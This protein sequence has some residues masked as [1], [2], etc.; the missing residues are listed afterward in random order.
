MSPIRD[1]DVMSSSF[2]NED[3][4][5]MNGFKDDEEEQEDDEDDDDQNPSGRFKFIQPQVN[6]EINF[7]HLNEIHYDTLMK[8]RHPHLHAED[9]SFGISNVK[10]FD[11]ILE[12]Q[13]YDISIPIHYDFVTTRLGIS[14]DLH[15]KNLE[16]SINHLSDGGMPYLIFR[17]DK[18]LPECILCY[19][20][21]IYSNVSPKFNIGGDLKLGYDLLSI[22]LP[23][24]KNIKDCLAKYTFALGGIDK[25]NSQNIQI[26]LQ[27][28]LITI[29][30]FILR[31]EILRMLSHKNISF[32]FDLSIW[33]LI[34]N[35]LTKGDLSTFD[36][37]LKKYQ[38]ND[39]ENE[40]I[41]V[42]LQLAYVSNQYLFDELIQYCQLILK[43]YISLDN[44]QILLQH[45]SILKMDQLFS[46]ISWFILNNFKLVLA[47]D[48][49]KLVEASCLSKLELKIAQLI[50]FY[51]PSPYIFKDETP[52][53]KIGKNK[54]F[55]YKFPPLPYQDHS[56]DLF[57]RDIEIFNAYYVH[58]W[59]QHLYVPFYNDEDLKKH[60]FNVKKKISLGDNLKLITKNKTL[61]KQAD[62][63]A[64]KSTI[65]IRNNSNSSS[66]SL[67]NENVLI[68][69]DEFIPVVPRKK[70]SRSNSSINTLVKSSRS[71]SMIGLSRPSSSSGLLSTSPT[72]ATTTTT[73]S[74]VRKSSMNGL[75]NGVNNV[76]NDQVETSISDI[77]KQNVS[78]PKKKPQLKTP[79]FNKSTATKLDISALTNEPEPENPII[80]LNPWGQSNNAKV[81]T[82][83]IKVMERGTA[84]ILSTNKLT[85]VNF[86]SIG[87]LKANNNKSKRGINSITMSGDSL[88]SFGGSSPNS[89]FLGNGDIY[90][91]SNS[92]NTKTLD[93][94]R[95]EA[96]FERWWQEESKKY[97]QQQQQPQISQPQQGNRRSGGSSSRKNNND[98]PKGK[99][100]NNANNKP[101][102]SDKNDKKPHNKTKKGKRSAD[103]KNDI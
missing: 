7:D 23:I 95:Q 35:Y 100:P 2:I 58:P 19:L 26:T 62:P 97:Q 74:A 86:P 45:A 59:L 25:E 55:K 31:N 92:L 77:L 47:D 4:V 63:I 102:S 50:E 68:D 67:S 43:D 28:E 91:D 44:Y 1:H 20:D 38:E 94:I 32:G 33:E 10:F 75:I 24:M 5:T 46:Q 88:R 83:D 98:K 61:E 39:D 37:L 15:T 21:Q 76:T 36:S 64:V 73:A 85:N 89:T 34:W 78:K 84:A 65:P 96:E 40:F 9:S 30:R 82:D 16:I 79:I 70:G 3:V 101:T 18:I 13:P 93:E 22:Q 12:I 71:G 53:V 87:E 51:V 11:S 90:Q 81:I 69:D 42:I 14:K 72:T 66:V 17:S 56:L 60:E 49:W 52:A 54:K 6:Y 103:I 80:K 48:S 8:L 41:N 57:Q 27:D 99:K 29:N